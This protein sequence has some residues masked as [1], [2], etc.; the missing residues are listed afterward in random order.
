MS[1]NINFAATFLPERVYL[2]KLLIFFRKN[3]G[4]NDF[5]ELYGIDNC[6]SS[7]YVQI[8]ELTGIPNGKST[9]KVVPHIN[10]LVGMGLLSKTSDWYEL[11]AFGNVMVEEDLSFEE[12]LTM[13]V[14]HVMLCDKYEGSEVYHEVFSK[15]TT[16][17]S[18]LRKNLIEGLNINNRVMSP[19]VGTYTDDAAFSKLRILREQDERLI[20]SSIKLDNHEWLP[21]F[22]AAIIHL[23]NT[24]FSGKHQISIIDFEEDT[25][26]SACLGY[27][28]SDTWGL[29]ENLASAGYLRVSALVTPPVIEA[30]MNEGEAWERLYDNLV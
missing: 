2:S 18:I 1:L 12:P 28:P 25:G 6:W 23:L 9:G 27:A 14:A 22:G 21:A 8:S 16:M 29:I 24:H 15:L 3:K 5:V 19:L 17:G 26:F 10:Y 13:L 7:I 4:R 20:L 11:S 30:V